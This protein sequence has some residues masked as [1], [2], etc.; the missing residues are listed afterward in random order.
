MDYTPTPEQAG[1][2]LYVVF[3]LPDGSLKAYTAR[4]SSIQKK[5]IFETELLGEFVV[6]A[7]AFEGEE[8][9]PAFYQELAEQEEV[10]KLF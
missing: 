8:F 6:T 5:L 2:L 10:R 9:S 3:R 7:F 4:Y 1:K